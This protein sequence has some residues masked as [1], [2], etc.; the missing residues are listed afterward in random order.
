MATTF[1]TIWQIGTH[2][3]QA[4]VEIVT[5]NGARALNAAILRYCEKYGL[6]RSHVWAECCKTIAA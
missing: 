5:V 3:G 2:R 4:V 1:P 6:E